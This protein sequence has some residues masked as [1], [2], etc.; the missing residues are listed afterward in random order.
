MKNVLFILTT[1]LL[2]ACNNELF[3][4]TSKTVKTSNGNFQ[5][6]AIT[7]TVETL[8]ANCKDSGLTWTDLKGNTEKVYITGKGKYFI[9]KTSAAGKLYRKYLKVEDKI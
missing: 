2:L 7:Q 8:T 4:Q 1:L 9:V 3:G 6:V 5:E